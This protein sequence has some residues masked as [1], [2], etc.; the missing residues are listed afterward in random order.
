MIIKMKITLKTLYLQYY[1]FDI[2]P[3]TPNANILCYPFFSG[4]IP[5]RCMKQNDMLKKG[6]QY[7][8]GVHFFR[9]RIQVHR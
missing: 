2:I 9:R 3:L 5:Y 4:H 8:G 7:T 6:L 1:F